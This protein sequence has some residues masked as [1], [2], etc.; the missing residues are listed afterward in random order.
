L[1]LGGGRWQ[2]THIEWNKR[3]AWVKP[4]EGH[5]RSRWLGGPGLSF[6]LCQ[7]ICSVLAS[8]EMSH[9]WS[10]RAQDEI[11]EARAEFEWV[12]ELGTT[13]IQDQASGSATWWTFGG[14]LANG[15]LAAGLMGIS[16]WRTTHNNLMI[17]IEPGVGLTELSETVNE[18]RK[19]PLNSWSSFEFANPLEDLK[20]S[21]CLPEDLALLIIHQRLSDPHSFQRVLG[22]S[23]I[24]SQ[25]TS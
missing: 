23:N 20:F 21:I 25:L 18:L 3:I 4:G 2:V 5:G 16:G 7:T 13:L 11:T 9:E 12:S 1:L 10:R 15:Q 19:T 14:Q 6:R 17:R 22:D 8:V 24:Q